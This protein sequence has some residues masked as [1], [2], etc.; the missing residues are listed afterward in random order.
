MTISAAGF[1]RNMSWEDDGPPHGHRLS[2]KRSVELISAGLF[3]EVL[4]PNWIFAWAPT[5]KIREPRDGF[6]KFRVRPWRPNW[7][8]CS[9]AGTYLADTVIPD[10]NDQRKASG[11]RGERRGLLSNLVDANEELV[12]DGDQRLSEEELIGARSTFEPVAF[13]FKPLQEKSS[14]FILPD[15]RHRYSSQHR[16]ALDLRRATD[17]R[18]YPGFCPEHACGA[19]SRTRIAVWAHPKCTSGLPFTG[20]FA[21]EPR[22]NC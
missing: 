18:S 14:C 2:L 5:K 4:C 21:R 7:V 11:G 3:V 9:R 15:M 19:P 13:L 10:G 22:S 6:A 17:I 8:R 20:K 12:D 1:G 16:W